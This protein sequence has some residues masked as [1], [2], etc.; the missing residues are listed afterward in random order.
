MER[1]EEVSILDTFENDIDLYM[2][3]FCEEQG[4]EDMRK[5]SQNVFHAALMF[6]RRH[7]FP[8]RKMLKLKGKLPGYIHPSTDGVSRNLSNSNCNAYDMELLMAIC[9][10]YV[11]MC[12]IYDK[13]VYNIG[14]SKLTGIDTCI[15]SQWGSEKSNIKLSTSTL[16]LHEK[17]EE[18]SEASNVA[19][20]ASYK[21][22]I[23]ILAYMNKRWQYNMPGMADRGKKERLGMEELPVLGAVELSDN[24]TQLPTASENEE[25]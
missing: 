17:L 10:Y 19:K 2:H 18:E 9:D 22:P 23:G 25:P 16:K 1:V 15:I 14:F 21:N 7:V 12:N 11:Y 3:V 20:L 24:G 5:E 6:I 8:D 13:I 4:I